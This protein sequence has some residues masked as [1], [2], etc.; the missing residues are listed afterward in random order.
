[1]QRNNASI[2]PL[3]AMQELLLALHGMSPHLLLRFIYLGNDPS[4]SRYVSPLAFRRYRVIPP[5][6]N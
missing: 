3:I 1:M 6:I 2:Q 4:Q 5:Y